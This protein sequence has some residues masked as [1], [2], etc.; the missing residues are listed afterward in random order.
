[1]GA[2]KSYRQER[3]CQLIKQGVPAFRADPMAGYAANNGAPYRLAENV[4]V[5]RRL[6]ELTRGLAVKTAVTIASLSE[7]IVEDREFARAHDNPSAAHAAT[8][9]L[10]KLHGHFIERKEIGQPGEFAGMSTEQVKEKL[11]AEHG[12]E[13]LK[14]LEAFL[15][16]SRAHRERTQGDA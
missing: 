5:K 11:A 10:G 15:Q 8:V 1:M 9:S 4:R 14:L 13:A 16:A 2:L 6:A 12:P 7:Q 3:F